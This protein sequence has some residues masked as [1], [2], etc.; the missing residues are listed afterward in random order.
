[1]K[2]EKFADVSDLQTFYAEEKEAKFEKLKEELTPLAKELKRLEHDK[3]LIE[4]DLKS[5]NK[6]ISSIQDN[7]RKIWGPHIAGAEKA[8]INCS[9]I[10]LE[11]MPKLN[12]TIEKDESEESEDGDESDAPRQQV[13]KWLMDN[14]Y[15]DIMSWDCNTNKMKKIARE[16]YQDGTGKMITGLKYS[17]FQLIKVK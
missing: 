1:M 8:S 14:G 4:L 11:T 16:L 6:D 12:I 9:G 17:Y 2:E 7:I 10:F 3:E 15:K 5:K 13:I